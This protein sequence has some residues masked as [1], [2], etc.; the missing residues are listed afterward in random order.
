MDTEQIK[1]RLGALAPRYQ[2]LA[3]L[4]VNLH[5]QE[6]LLSVARSNVDKTR[7]EVDDLHRL[8]SQ[9]MQEITDEASGVA[10]MEGKREAYELAREIATKA[11]SAEVA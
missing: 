10:T 1:A 5:G 9:T 4:K 11:V 3:A 2:Q 6:T 7:K 8:L